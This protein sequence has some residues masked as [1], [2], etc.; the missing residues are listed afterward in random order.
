MKQTKVALRSPYFTPGS[1]T[2]KKIRSAEAR[3]DRAASYSRASV[4][5]NATQRMSMTWGNV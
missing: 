3:R 2:V 5:D 1:V 4:M